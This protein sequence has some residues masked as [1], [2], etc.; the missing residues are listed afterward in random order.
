MSDFIKS[1]ELFGQ[2]VSFKKCSKCS[3]IKKVESF[4]N[5]KSSSCGKMSQCKSCHNESTRKW[6]EAIKSKH[7]GKLETV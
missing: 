6:T 2:K 1:V 3:E 7:D 4:Y 5:L